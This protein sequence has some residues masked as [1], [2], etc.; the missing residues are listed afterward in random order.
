MSGQKLCLAQSSI[1]VQVAVVK[2]TLKPMEHLEHIATS[3]DFGHTLLASEEADLRYQNQ[4]LLQRIA[5]LEADAA[6]LK[7]RNDELDAFAHTVAHDLRT[8][9]NWVNGYIEL[10]IKDWDILNDNERIEYAHATHHGAQMMSNIINELLL[11]ASLNDSDVVYKTVSMEPV[12]RR[13]KLRLQPMF[14]QYNAELIVPPSFPTV[15]GYGP[16]IEGVWV[17]YISN[18]IKYGGTPPQI[19]IG[20]FD[21]QDSVRFWVRDNGEGLTAEQQAQLFTPFT[22]TGKRH[23]TGYGLGLSIVRRIVEKLGGTV[24]IRSKLGEGSCFIF[25]LPRG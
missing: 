4:Q 7:A 11:L 12:L 8:P 9:L 6:E 3:A 5:Q 22:G 10:L 2:F 20:Y 18:A 24:N 15:F 19:E 17:N 16:W 23:G 21:Q 14:R 25:T 1:H 13:A